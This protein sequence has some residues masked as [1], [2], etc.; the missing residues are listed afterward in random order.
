MVP[1]D[2]C[3]QFRIRDAKLS[4]IALFRRPNDKLNIV[5][6]LSNS[7]CLVLAVQG[8]LDITPG[9]HFIRVGSRDTVQDIVCRHQATKQ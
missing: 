3:V 7:I 8:I 1:V 5:P 2:H 9:L 4:W 6:V